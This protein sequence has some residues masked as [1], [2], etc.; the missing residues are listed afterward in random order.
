MRKGGKCRGD[1]SCMHGVPRHG[2]AWL[3]SELVLLPV[4]QA[5]HTLAGSGAAGRGTVGERS[6]PRTL[7]S[8]PSTPTHDLKRTSPGPRATPS[9]TP[10][11]KRSS[12][13]LRVKTPS[14]T[15]SSL[16]R[17]ESPSNQQRLSPTF[18]KARRA[19]PP[20]EG[21]PQRT[22]FSCGTQ[23]EA[24]VTTRKTCASCPAAP[25]GDAPALL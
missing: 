9:P 3:V 20:E 18:V 17:R 8:R 24:E 7:G 11:E 13:S 25:S 10:S 14:P 5:D 6:G 2:R 16:S 21:S 1:N 22:T 12:P 15:P 4:R 23:V 19:T